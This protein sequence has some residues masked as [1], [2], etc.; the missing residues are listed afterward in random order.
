V[1]KGPIIVI[2]AGIGGLTAAVSLAAK[3]QEVLVV[4][5]AATPGGKMREIAIGNAHIDAGP[6]VFTMRWVFDDIFSSAGARL[7]DYLKLTPANTVARYAWS[8]SERLD[9]YADVTRSADAIGRF[10]GAAEARGFL[11]FV[12][13]ARRIYETLKQPFMCSQ[14]PTPFTLVLRAGILGFADLLRIKSF[15]TMWNAVSRHF[16]DARLRQLFGRFATY[17]G[18]SPFQAPGTLMLVAHVEQEGIWLIDGG[19]HRLPCAFADLLGRLGGKIRYGAE[20]SG[21]LTT[22]HGVSGVKLANGEVIAAKAVVVNADANA[23]ATGLFGAAVTRAVPPLPV[24][25]RSLSAVTWTLLARTHGFPLSRHN[26]FF[27][28]DYRSEFSEIS[29]GFPRE[30]T[31]YVCAQDRDGHSEGAERLL[32]IVNAPAF[33]D[34]AAAPIAALETA[35]RRKLAQCGLQVEW[36]PEDCKI[37]T[38]TDFA[39]LYPATGGALYGRAS[40]GW[41]ASFQRPSASTRIPGLYL[42]GGSTHPGPGV[43]MAALSGRLAAESILSNR[44][45]I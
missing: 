5:R 40:H 4:E 6:T 14:R 11:G 20:A 41:T 34:Q 23:V 2:G 9:L 8:A 16:R 36:R 35:A 7:D 27:S 38:P 3:G 28:S 1:V 45:S 31:V 33:G 13:D 43:P 15:Q 42:A 32:L 25:R 37:T 21:I 24:H 26:V 44:A 12:A 17:C 22:R 10:A 39:K 29:R 18:S 19:M 30:P